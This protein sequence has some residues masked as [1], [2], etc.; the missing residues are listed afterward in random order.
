[1][2]PAQS[3][4][5]GVALGL[6]LRRPHEAVAVAHRAVVVDPDAVQHRVAFERERVAAERREQRVGTVAEVR[7][8]QVVGKLA[9]DGQ[10]LGVA[11]VA[12]RRED[13]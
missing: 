2:I 12:D 5:P 9:D 13:A 1:M 4:W 10:G 11:L 6:E 8:A 3:A 7:A